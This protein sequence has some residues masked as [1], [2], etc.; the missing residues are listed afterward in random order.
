MNAAPSPMRNPNL[1][2]PPNLQT[3]S[4]R[5]SNTQ[6]MSQRS[7]IK[8]SEF[9]KY[10]KGYTIKVSTAGNFNNKDKVYL[11][12]FI[13][14]EFDV[15]ELSSDEASLCSLKYNDFK[16][17]SM[18]FSKRIT[19]SAKKQSLFDLDTGVTIHNMTTK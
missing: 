16:R 3:N 12:L 14:P 6:P 7:N 15:E 9:S 18:Y 17:N 19:I 11:T 8:S 4:P 13:D 1:L 2:F 10:D 5:R